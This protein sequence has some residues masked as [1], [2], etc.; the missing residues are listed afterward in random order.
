M[1]DLRFRQRVHMDLPVRIRRV[2]PP[3]ECVEIKTTLDVSRNGLLFRTRESYEMN[4]TVWVTM[5]YSTRAE[6]KGPEFPATVVRV[7]KMPSG[8]SEVGVQFHSAAPDKWNHSVY[9]VPGKPVTSTEKREKNRVR[10][11][12]PVRVR[13]GMILDESVTLD[14]SR[15]GVLFASS[16]AYSIAQK[17]FVVVPYQPVGLISGTLVEEPAEVVRFVERA[18]VRG[19]AVQFTARAE[20]RPH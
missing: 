16:Q 12:L 2:P 3:R 10:M 13:S 1:K 14:V 19:V 15:T 18:G 6:D 8:D 11:T 17:V 7:I 5:P 9:T 20:A 4:G